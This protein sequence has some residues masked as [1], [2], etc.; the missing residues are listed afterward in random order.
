MK[1]SKEDDKKFLII[2]SFLSSSSIFKLIFK[3][4]HNTF[5][6]G[7][8]DYAETAESLLSLPNPYLDNFFSDKKSTF[9]RFRGNVVQSESAE[10]TEIFKSW[11]FFIFLYWSL[12]GTALIRQIT[13]NE[14]LRDNATIISQY[15]SILV[16]RD[17]CYL[18]S[19]KLVW[20][21]FLLFC[22]LGTSFNSVKK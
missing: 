18:S 13:N 21:N 11:R 1:V 20:F 5:Y 8:V 17:P 10:S 9:R 15:L 22:T 19:K 4:T 2:K 16:S 7:Q 12:K 6:R 3:P 14:C